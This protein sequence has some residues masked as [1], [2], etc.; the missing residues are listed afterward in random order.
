V[1][2]HTRRVSRPP[3]D[4]RSAVRGDRHPV[5]ERDVAGNP[6]DLAAWCSERDQARSE[7][8]AGEVEADG[9]DVGVAPVIDHDVIPRLGRD[10]GQVGMRDERPAGLTAQQPPLR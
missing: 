5:R 10:R 8:A 6:A 3:S 1:C 4:Q 9:I 2:A 7:L